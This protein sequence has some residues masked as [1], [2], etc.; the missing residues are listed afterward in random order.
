MHL[1]PS[2]HGK[3]R[4]KRWEKW[5]IFSSWA[6]KLLWMVTVA[7][8]LEND[9][10]LEGK[11]WYLGRKRRQ[12]IKKQR[13]HFASKSLYSQSY[14]LSISHVQMWELSHKEGRVLNNW[15]CWSV[16]LEKTLESPLDSKKI[17]PVNPKETNPEYS[18]EG[19]MLKLKLLYFGHLMMRADSLEKT[20]MLG[21]IEDRRR[22]GWERMTWLEGITDSWTW[23]WANSGR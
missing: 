23:T 5:Q 2:L 3:Y 17:K 22:R 21:K 8:K 13:H 11:L 16:V 7:M 18:L 20:L 4:G 19:L 14:G 1:A 15:Y 9:C 10:F 12:R 6:L